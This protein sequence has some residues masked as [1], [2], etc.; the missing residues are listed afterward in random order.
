MSEFLI[1]LDDFCKD[2]M[3]WEL[4]EKLKEKVP[5]LKLNLFTIPGR[6]SW[7]WIQ[8]MRTVE[9]IQMIPHGHI[10]STSRECQNWS[11]NVA[12]SYLRGLEEDGWI[13]GWKSPGW[14]ISD[15][16]YQALLEMGWWVADQEYN[17]DRRPEGLRTY[18]LDSPFKI[19]GH[20]GHWGA[21][22]SNSLEYIF[23][24]IAALKGEF[25]FIDD[26]CEQT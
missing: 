6:S 5:K 20:I 24:S 10:H 8:N 16:T 13:H 18:L 14:Q 22:N 1:D 15:G 9:W 7:G 3:D 21:H 12:L 2:N 26:L 23:N 19:H 17:N 4:I 11:Y 25:G